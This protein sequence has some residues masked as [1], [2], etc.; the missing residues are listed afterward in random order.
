MRRPDIIQYT[1]SINAKGNI[2]I[3]FQYMGAPFDS[4]EA[5]EA[6]WEKINGISGV[7]LARRLKGRPTIPLAALTNP[8][9]LHQF[10]AIFDEFVDRTITEQLQA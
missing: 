10:I 4:L 9:A 1:F 7:S 8:E 6:L 2:V 3:Q 5:R